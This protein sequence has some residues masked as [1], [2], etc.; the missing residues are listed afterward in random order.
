MRDSAERQTLAGG[1]ILDAEASAKKF[2]TPEQMRFLKDRARAPLQ[3][4]VFVQTQLARITSSRVRRCS[5]SRVSKAEEISAELEKLAVEKQLF[6]RGDLVADGPWWMAAITRALDALDA[7]H[8][9]HPHHTGLEL[10][11]LRNLFPNQT[12]EMLGALLSD[13]ARSLSFALAM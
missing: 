8:K 13:F 6:L 12:S 3:L 9:A 5:Q 4:R 1:I 2:R 7:E 11:K 10:A